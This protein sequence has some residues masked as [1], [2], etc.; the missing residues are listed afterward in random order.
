MKKKYRE[1]DVFD[2]SL[3]VN[4]DERAEKIKTTNINILLNKI[5][6]D[7]KKNLKKSIT[8]VLM[9]LSVISLISIF[10]LI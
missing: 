9:L 2:M 7:E 1:I 10:V 6:L 3:A 5:R 4:R 8:L